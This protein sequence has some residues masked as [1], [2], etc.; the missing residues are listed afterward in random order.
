MKKWIIIVAAVW[1]SVGVGLV[2]LVVN[3]YVTEYRERARQAEAQATYDKAFR[4]HIYKWNV[5]QWA[6]YEKSGKDP[7]FV[8]DITAEERRRPPRRRRQARQGAS[9]TGTAW[10]G[11]ARRSTRVRAQ[12]LHV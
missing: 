9:P 10:S 4:D 12:P 7:N 5:A 1:I 11:T 8:M 2:A 6:E 3:S